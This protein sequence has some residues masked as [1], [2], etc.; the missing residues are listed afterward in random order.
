MRDIVAPFSFSFFDIRCFGRQDPL[1]LRYLFSN[2]RSH[3]FSVCS[4][5]FYAQ[6]TFK[7]HAFLDSESNKTNYIKIIG[8]YIAAHTGCLFTIDHAECLLI[9]K[10]K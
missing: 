4:H 6:N 8:I 5:S 10:G 9:K 1:S 2:H 7:L 3:G